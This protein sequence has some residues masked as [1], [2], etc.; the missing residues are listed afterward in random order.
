MSDIELLQQGNML[1]AQN[2]SALLFLISTG[3]VVLVCILL[4]KFLRKFF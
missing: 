4:Y 1:L 3:T 2:Y